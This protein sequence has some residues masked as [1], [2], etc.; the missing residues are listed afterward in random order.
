MTDWTKD[1]EQLKETIA[2]DREGKSP[3]DRII[4][5]RA[6]AATV[7][8]NILEDDNAIQS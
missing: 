6:A 8:L 7:V 2:A 1:I 4:S 3:D 5:L